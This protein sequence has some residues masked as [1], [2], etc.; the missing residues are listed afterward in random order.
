[1]LIWLVLCYLIVKQHKK[2]S[3]QKEQE[4]YGVAR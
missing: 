1:V 3:T 4:S 2:I